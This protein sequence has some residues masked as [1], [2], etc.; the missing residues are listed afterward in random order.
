MTNAIKTVL[1]TGHEGYIGPILVEKLLDRGYNVRG[2]DIGYFSGFSLFE[3]PAANTIPLFDLDAAYVHE[4]YG[5]AGL[6]L[7][8][9]EVNG[10][11][12]IHDIIDRPDH[13]AGV[14]REIRGHLAAEHCQEKRL[15]ELI[16]I[17]ES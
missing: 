15:R 13:Y 3:T 10:D 6:E 7:L 9:P 14:V 1:V 11:E 16:D 4:I 5:A 12:K 8:L 2:M 17:I